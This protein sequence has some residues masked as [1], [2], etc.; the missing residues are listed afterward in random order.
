MNAVTNIAPAVDRSKFIGG[1]DIGA[2]LNIAP[3]TWSRHSPYSLWVDKTTPRIE[4]HEPRTGPLR[5]GKRWEAVVAEM[6][7]EQLVHEG[8]KVEILDSNKRYVDPDVPYFACEIDFEIRLD[9][10][11]ETTNVELKT[12]H[13]FRA[14][15]WGESGTDD[16]PVYYTAQAMWG[17]GITRRKRCLV[18]PLFGADSIKT[19]PVEADLETIAAIRARAGAFWTN[20]VLAGVPPE[21]THISDLDHLYK[22]EDDAPALVADDPL[23]EKVLRMRAIQREIKARE[24]EWDVLEFDV[25]RAMGPCASLVVNGK[26]AISWKSQKWSTL[27]FDRLKKEQPKILKEY[28]RSGSTRQFKLKQFKWQEAGDDE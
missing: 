7:V 17:L 6:L 12:V 20:H 13:P 1:S 14:G 27:D 9:D 19:F 28:A 5:R 22:S 3:L 4:Q 2:L 15:D 24:A 10:E 16:L 26:D 18:A 23:I 8:H 11:E 25:K 21:P